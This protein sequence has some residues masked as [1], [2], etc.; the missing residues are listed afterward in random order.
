MGWGGH[1]AENLGAGLGSAGLASTIW[2]GASDDGPDEAKGEATAAVDDVLRPHALQV[3]ASAGLVSS[4]LCCCCCGWCIA[5]SDAN[6][7][8]AAFA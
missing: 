6:D 2:A 8:R 1:V 3:N 7:G 4:G 5:A